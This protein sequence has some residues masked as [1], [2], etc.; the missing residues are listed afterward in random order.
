[1]P[2]E[3]PTPG[4][5]TPHYQAYVD[6]APEGD[7]EEVLIRQRDEVRKLL[8]GLTSE[9]FH[10]RYAPGKW[11]VAEV[12]GHVID[13]ERVLAYRLLA[14]ARGDTTPLPGFDQD[15][16]VRQANFDARDLDDLLAEHR[17]VRDA[18]LALLPSLD[19]ERQGRTGVAN[20]AAFTVRAMPF[21][22]AGHERHHLTVLRERYL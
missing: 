22:I 1:M 13:C 2:I 21:V 17:A 12:L 16:Y 15:E 19:L 4:E 20:G 9:Q 14:F 7:V 10:Y 5:V 3:R 6:R 11:S 18:T 8:S